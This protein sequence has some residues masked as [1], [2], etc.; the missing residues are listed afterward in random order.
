ML[1]INHAIEAD[2]SYMKRKDRHI[3]DSLILPKIRNKEIYILRE[4]GREIG[5]MRFGYFWDNTPFMNMLWLEEEERGKGYGRELVL[6][7]E[8]TMQQQGFPTVMTSTQSN[9]GAQH[10][11]RKLGYRDIGCL[12]QDSDPLEVILGKTLS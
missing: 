10:F 9:E 2:Y 5:W 7:W 11:Y 6:Y 12:L 3:A 4:A 1:T 8:K